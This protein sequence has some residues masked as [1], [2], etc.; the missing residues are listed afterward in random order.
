VSLPM[1]VLDG[2][3]PEV[4]F[5]VRFAWLAFKNMYIRG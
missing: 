5:M 2:V 3:S 4:V 1:Y